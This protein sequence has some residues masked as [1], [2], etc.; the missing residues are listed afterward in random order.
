MSVVIT[1][2]SQIIEPVKIGFAHFSLQI[3]SQLIYKYMIYI[4][5]VYILLTAY[6]YIICYRFSSNPGRKEEWI[7]IIKLNIILGRSCRLCSSHFEEKFIDRTSVAC[8]RL[9]ENAIPHVQ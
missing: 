9:K 6:N 3:V 7:E 4:F 2:L 1:L 5:I 8:I